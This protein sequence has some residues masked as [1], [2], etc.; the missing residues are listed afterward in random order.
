MPDVFKSKRA[1][2]RPSNRAPSIVGFEEGF[3]EA[4][5]DYDGRVKKNDRAIPQPRVVRYPDAVERRDG[6]L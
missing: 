2:Q 5:K 6:K 4:V 1:S 3:D